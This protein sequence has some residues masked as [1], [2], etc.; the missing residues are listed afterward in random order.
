[1]TDK[2]QVNDQDVYIEKLAKS[3]AEELKSNLHIREGRN[4]ENRS[5]P[6]RKFSSIGSRGSNSSRRSNSGVEDPQE[7]KESEM[8]PVKGQAE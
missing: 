2:V 4:Q 7:E 1:M 8:I 3:L 6:R 5:S